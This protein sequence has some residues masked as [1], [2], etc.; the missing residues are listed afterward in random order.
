MYV[1]SKSEFSKI[2]EIIHITNIYSHL[3]SYIIHVKNVLVNSSSL[4][5]TH[6]TTIQ[7]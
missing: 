5:I 1:S 6:T 3:G 4:P 7:W 2:V